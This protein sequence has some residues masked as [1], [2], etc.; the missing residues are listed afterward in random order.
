M[1]TRPTIP[2]HKPVPQG[3]TYATRP[4]AYGAARAAGLTVFARGS[5]VIAM[6]NGSDGLAVLYLGGSEG[7]YRWDRMSEVTP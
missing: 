7:D 2:M 5:K 6:G 3:S 1:T 4:E